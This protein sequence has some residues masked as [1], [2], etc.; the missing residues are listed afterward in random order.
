MSQTQS[1]GTFSEDVSPK[2]HPDKLSGKE[3]ICCTIRT[4]AKGFP[5]I[6]VGKYRTL[7]LCKKSHAL[8]NTENKRL[9]EMID[10]INDEVISTNDSKQSILDG[11]SDEENAI[12]DVMCSGCK[13][14]DSSSMCGA[15]CKGTLYIKEKKGQTES[16][17]FFCKG[18][19]L[20][21]YLV[22]HYC[23]H[24][25][26]KKKKTNPNS[27]VTNRSS[28]KRTKDQIVD[29]S[30]TDDECEHDV[31]E[32]HTTP[33]NFTQYVIDCNVI[34]KITGI[35][36]K[37]FHELI[38]LRK[39]TR[40]NALGRPIEI[41]VEDEIM[42]TLTHLRQYCTDQF[43]SCIFQIEKRAIT[44]IRIRVLDWLYIELK[45]YICMQTLQFRMDNSEEYFKHLITIIIDGSEQPAFCC[46]SAILDF[47]FYSAKKN[48]HSITILM[49]MTPSGHIGYLSPCFPGRVNDNE[50]FNKTSSHWLSEMDAS[51]FIFGDSGFKGL[52]RVITPPDDPSLR[53]IFSS[54]RIRVENKFREIKIFKSCKERIRIKT[55]SKTEVL[56]IAHMRWVVVGAFCNLNWT[57]YSNKDFEMSCP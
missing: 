19:H 42:I 10:K 55:Q 45:R 16:N 14:V 40:L 29:E 49:A 24:K 18:S 35:C 33:S 27:S 28:K 12:E 56:R 17:I 8:D 23:S 46:D 54:V 21:K 31:I 9:A 7:I 39:Q 38:Q 37:G 26:G 4:A 41:P 44:T 36:E 5:K 57:R 50:L 51:E 22:R 11:E 30:E 15:V 34:H 3:C 52:P 1:L 53:K 13:N 25:S 47:E 32:T 48:Q 6:Y 43:L 2:L 20:I